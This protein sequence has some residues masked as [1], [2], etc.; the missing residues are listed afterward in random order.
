M[1]EVE[2]KAAEHFASQYD[3]LV[4]WHDGPPAR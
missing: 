1:M 2:T 3:E 4:R